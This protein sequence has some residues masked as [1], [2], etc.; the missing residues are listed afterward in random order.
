MSAEYVTDAERDTS[1]ATVVEVGRA[2]FFENSTKVRTGCYIVVSL[3]AVASF[4]LSYLHTSSSLSIRS[5]T[6]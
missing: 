6:S 3:T 4:Y 5:S 1:P 2:V